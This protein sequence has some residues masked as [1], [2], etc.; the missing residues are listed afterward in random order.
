MSNSNLV[1]LVSYSPNHSGRRQNP[2]ESV[3]ITG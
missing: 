2:M 1:N 3:M